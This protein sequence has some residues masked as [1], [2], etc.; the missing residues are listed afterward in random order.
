M[1]HNG[2][3]YDFVV[4][5]QFCL[6]FIPSVPKSDRKDAEALFK[7]NKNC[8]NECFIICFKV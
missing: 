5:W 6:A 4:D 2:I 8:D 7:P 1:K 3:G